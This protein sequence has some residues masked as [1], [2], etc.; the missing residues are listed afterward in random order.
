MPIELVPLTRVTAPPATEFLAAVRESQASLARWLPWCHADYGQV[1]VERWYDTADAMWLSRAGCPMTL[2]DAET[3]RLLGGVGIHDILLYGKREAEIGYWVRLSAR[4]RGVA[5]TA[6]RAAAAF[7]FNELA[8]VR[9]T[10]RIALANDSSRR[11]AERAQ[12]RFEGVARHGI[13]HGEARF[14]AAVYSLL[15]ADL[16]V[17]WAP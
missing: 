3:G 8:L 1:D 12:A 17:P 15:P 5:S 14:D 10:L 9:A 13:V 7:A 2:R 4:G 16:R 11:A 6:I